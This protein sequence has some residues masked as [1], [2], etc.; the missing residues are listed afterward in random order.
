MMLSFKLLLVVLFFIIL[1]TLI[2]KKNKFGNIDEIEDVITSYKQ[3][4]IPNEIINNKLRNVKD[5]YKSIIL[6][7]YGCFANL[8]NKFFIKKINRNNREKTFDS[9][10]VIEPEKLEQGFY[11]LLKKVKENGYTQFANKIN[12]KLKKLGWDDIT[13]QEIGILAKYAGYDYLS[14]YKAGLHEK[15][16]V[17]LT[18]SPP[19]DL[20]NITGVFSE[21]KYKNSLSSS[22]LPGYTL[23]PK[24]NNYTNE[25]ENDTS[26]EL[27]C[28]FPCLPN[29]KPDTFVDSNGVTRQYMC[30]SVGYPT[31][32]TH[33]RY[34][35]YKINLI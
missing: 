4:K 18:Y 23:T 20:H 29:N 2:L 8:E 19:M 27:S 5:P 17:Y 9:A 1:L 11:D 28:G 21:E 22:D 3:D 13:I 10:I 15:G 7:P 31:I 26:K 35:V 24:L 34:A 33:S 12:D 6:E 25:S 16:R 14:I 30:G 32:K